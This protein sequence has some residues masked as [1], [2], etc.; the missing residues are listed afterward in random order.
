MQDDIYTQNQVRTL[1]RI[2]LQ[3]LRILRPGIFRFFYGQRRKSFCVLVNTIHLSL[4]DSFHK[5]L[6][7]DRNESMPNPITDIMTY[8]MLNKT[9]ILYRLKVKSYASECEVSND[10]QNV[11]YGAAVDSHYFDHLMEL[12]DNVLIVQ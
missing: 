11:I 10:T 8:M 5:Y 7:I 2:V 3:F 9:D 1:I 4:H 6:I 12:I